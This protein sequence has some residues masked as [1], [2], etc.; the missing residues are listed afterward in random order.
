MTILKSL[1]SLIVV[2]LSPG[3]DNL[4]KG[5]WELAVIL[6]L[7]ITATLTFGCIR[8]VT[9]GKEQCMVTARGWNFGFYLPCYEFMLAAYIYFSF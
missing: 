4:L 3:I 5:N 7:S 2:F 6:E 9:T 1:N 8:L